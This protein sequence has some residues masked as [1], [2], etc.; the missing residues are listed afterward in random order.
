V[1]DIEDLRPS[2]V[3]Q[4]I[5]IAFRRRWLLIGS[6]VGCLL[7]GLIATLLM[8]PLYTASSSIEVRRESN[9]LA[10]VDAAQQSAPRDS[11]FYETQYGLLRSESLAQRVADELSLADNANFFEISGVSAADDWFEN[12][13]LI[14]SA[15][16]KPERLRI[17]GKV[18]LK[19]FEVSPVRQ[20]SLVNLQFTSPN[21]AISQQVVNAWSRLY[22][23]QTLER[24]FEETSY[25]R[26]FLENRLVELRKRIDAS[27]RR[28]V[29]YASQEGIINLPSSAAG[30]SGPTNERSLAADDLASFNTA[31]A[32]ATSDRMQAQS[33][34]SAP[35]SSPEALQNNAIAGFRQTRAELSGQYAKL[36][37]QFEPGYPQ[38]KALQRQI[39]QLDQAINAEE[40]RVSG[41]VQDE[42]RASLARESALS[43]KVEALKSSLL[44]T[45]RRSIQYNIFKRDVD[46]NQQLYDALL[47]RYK[48]IGVAG[49]VGVNNI[50]VV[51]KAE[52][53]RGP[54]SPN[55]PLNLAIAAAVGLLIGA[56]VAWLLEQLHQGI[57]D[58]AE[59]ESLLGVPLLGTIPKSANGTPLVD[60]R[61]PKTAT[62]E[63]YLS[64]RT[65]LAFATPHGVPSTIAITSTVSAEGKSTTSYALATQLAQ[66]S[67]RGAV[68]ID[69]DMRSPSIHALLNLNNER[70]LS[71]FLSGSD[72]LAGL[73]QSTGIGSLAV[74]PSG[75]RPPSA[76]DL[77]T[78]GRL[79]LLLQ[80][81]LKQ[82]DHVVIDMPPVM[83]LAD[84]LLVGAQVEGILFVTEAHRTS[85]NLVKGALYRLRSANLAP[86]GTVLTKYD[87]KQGHYGNGYG[88]G[89]G[90]GEETDA[91]IQNGVQ[92]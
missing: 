22:I 44:D 68:L 16:P 19:R 25:A 9:G 50:S 36:M 47:Q 92:G 75:P 7:I 15:P 71:N 61:D 76:P 21:A 52:L 40:R 83:G 48:A 35:L 84:T 90:Y 11:E 29:D 2:L 45:R 18:L 86:L 60:L 77:L 17:A 87:S 63:A 46:T 70:G 57:N 43:S 85:V 27:E 39:A 23:Q 59:V 13:R 1:G 49:G 20:S 26:T 74:I 67:S 91:A 28:L 80:E 4:I 30:G 6:I 10:D 51:D 3:S 32:Q 72:D 69:A 31:L 82:F 34:L 54:S 41:T 56:T 78:G 5:T 58:P 33:R 8:S 62:T 14:N 79:P 73:L 55:L 89:Y 37:Q 12:G 66:T 38:A 42:Y 64:L 24:R 81:L 88:Y 53:P 65:R